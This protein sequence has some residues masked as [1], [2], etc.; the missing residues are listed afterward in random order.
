[1]LSTE[2]GQTFR[3]GATDIPKLEPDAA[4]IMVQRD[5]EFLNHCSPIVKSGFT[6][7]GGYIDTVST[8]DGDYLTRDALIT[9]PKRL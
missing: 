1:M 9:L 8:G 7:E 5:V 3:A 6:L 2:Y 4:I